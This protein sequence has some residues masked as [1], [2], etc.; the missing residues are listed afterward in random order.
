MKTRPISIAARLE[1][2]LDLYS[3]MVER[4]DGTFE[5]DPEFGLIDRDDFI[6]LLDFPDI[7]QP[8]QAPASGTESEK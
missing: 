4:E 5:R 3:P 8:G 6:R 2:V 7:M 1:Q